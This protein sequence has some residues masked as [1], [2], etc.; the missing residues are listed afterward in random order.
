MHIL[1]IIV[2]GFRRLKDNFTIDFLTT[3]SITKASNDAELL[4]IGDKLFIPICQVFMG[5]HG[6]GKSSIISLI[7]LC[8]A[9]LNE[10]NI[11]YH[12]E[13]FSQEKITL[14]IFF[15]N[16][17]KVYR[18]RCELFP[19][20][21]IKMMQSEN[22][23]L[24]KNQELFVKNVNIQNTDK[25]W[26]G[27]YV[28][29][30]IEC[31]SLTG[32]KSMVSSFDFKM[33]YVISLKDN[34]KVKMMKIINHYLDYINKDI[35]LSVCHFFGL[36]I[37]NF[38]KIS[39]DELMIIYGNGHKKVALKNELLVTYLSLGTI[40]GLLVYLS[41]YLTLKL[42]GLLMIDGLEDYLQHETVISVINLFLD[43]RMNRKG[44]LFYFST[45]DA[46]LLDIFHRND[47]IHVVFKDDEQMIDHNILPSFFDKRMRTLKSN[48]ISQQ[49]VPCHIDYSS[50][51]ELKEK[52][53]KYIDY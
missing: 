17:I 45:Y 44:A 18:Y 6:C 2:T 52:I 9:C 43:K 27:R 53:F 8:I 28:R 25:L 16:S 10:D 22:R 37:V 26:N 3:Q 35:V 36:D 41:A 24:I 29:V 32:T 13:D 47:H 33:P 40:R 19:P 48:M 42:G 30:P 34:S 23:V 49:N 12:P 21:F 7:D 5:S 14:S 1:K 38:K 46:R 51:K 11:L 4:Q 31:Q 50:F 15:T 20:S 39:N